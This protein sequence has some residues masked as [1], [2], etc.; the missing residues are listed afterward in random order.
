M[1]LKFYGTMMCPDCVDAHKVLED[2]QTSYEFVDITGSVP[3]LKEFTR[4]RDTN[5]AFDDAKAEG[6]LGIPAFVV[7]EDAASVT[8]NV[9]DVVQK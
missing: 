4:L 2:S 9:E 6:Y 7:D 3:A 8:L 1:A 5:P